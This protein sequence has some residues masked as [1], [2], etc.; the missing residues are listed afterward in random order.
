MNRKEQITRN[1]ERYKVTGSIPVDDVGGGG[2]SGVRKLCL[3]LFNRCTS[4]KGGRLPPPRLCCFVE[5]S[6]NKLEMLF[7]AFWCLFVTTV[8]YFKQWQQCLL[9]LLPKDEDQWTL[10]GPLYSLCALSILYKK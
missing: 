3:L 6:R 10:A 4:A 1:R 7:S 5:I 9:R 8:Q 2:V